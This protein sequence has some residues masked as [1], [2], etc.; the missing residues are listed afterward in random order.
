MAEG[1]YQAGSECTATGLSRLRHSFL[2]LK[3]NS[4]AGECPCA[5]L[6]RVLVSSGVFSPG[7]LC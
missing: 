5:Q 2:R 3:S 1:K 4:R 7:Y 6:Q